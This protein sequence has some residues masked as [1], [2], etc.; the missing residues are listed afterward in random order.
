MGRIIYP[1][2]Y[3]KNVWNHQPV[4]TQNIMRQNGGLTTSLMVIEPSNMWIK[5]SKHGNGTAGNGAI[6][7]IELVQ[8]EAPKRYELV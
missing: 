3:G 7:D 4:Y 6:L 8:C 2:Y 1:I 5:T